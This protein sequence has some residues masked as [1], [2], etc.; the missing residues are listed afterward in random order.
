M[1]IKTHKT[2]EPECHLWGEEFSPK[3]LSSIENIVFRNKNELGEI[4]GRGPY[5][6]KGAPYGSCVLVVPEYVELHDSIMWMAEFIF[7]N[8][9]KFE[10]AGA[11]DIVMWIYWTG[12]QGNMSFDSKELKMIAKSNVPLCVDYIMMEEKNNKHGE[13][14]L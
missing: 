4:L 1:K 9:E 12:F 7:I 11:T 10:K 8:K 13:S 2:I 6:K 14:E 5:K 3:E